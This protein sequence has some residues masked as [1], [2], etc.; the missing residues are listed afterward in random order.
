[1][2]V[3]EKILRRVFEVPWFKHYDR[4]IIEQHA[5]AYKKV[6]ANHRELLADDTE[7]DADTGGYS[8]FFSSQRNTG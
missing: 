7:T 8:S 2:P 5:D 1:L 4:E 3:S 6:L